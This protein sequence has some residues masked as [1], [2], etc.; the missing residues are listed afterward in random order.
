[1]L[2]VSEIA[3][4]LNISRQA[5]YKYIN[6]DKLKA[7]KFE[8]NIRVKQEELDKFLNQNK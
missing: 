7:V 2:K 1:M 8:G 5:V 6:E 3:E 4:M